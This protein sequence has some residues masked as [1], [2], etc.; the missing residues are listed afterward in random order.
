[1]NKIIN[2]KTWQNFKLRFQHPANW[3]IDISL[4]DTVFRDI[5]SEHKNELKLWRFHRRSAPDE[6][7]HQISFLCYT[8][9][10]N[11][12]LIQENLFL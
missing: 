3:W 10:E 4:I 8:E 11:A 9:D 7:G 1:M 5:I 12:A 6:S 2:M